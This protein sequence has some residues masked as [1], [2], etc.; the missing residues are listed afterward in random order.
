[1]AEAKECRRL[2]DASPPWMEDGI[3]S[4]SWRDSPKLPEYETQHSHLY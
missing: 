1:M 3:V 4:T 2:I